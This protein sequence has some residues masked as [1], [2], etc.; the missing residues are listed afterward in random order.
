[1]DTPWKPT[2][3]TPWTPPVESPQRPETTASM[4]SDVELG[5]TVQQHISLERGHGN[6][7][8]VAEL[9]D[10]V[11]LTETHLASP[12]TREVIV[13]RLVS[14][15]ASA[16]IDDVPRWTLRKA[17]SVLTPTSGEGAWS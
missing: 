3:Q 16:A 13:A 12:A 5:M 6:V 9:L 11:S 15:G 17:L 8:A 10:L 2:K 1:M 4:F 14:R 7:C